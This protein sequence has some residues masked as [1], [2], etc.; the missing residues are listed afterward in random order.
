MKLFDESGSSL[1]SGKVV[2]G[3]CLADFQLG[4]A[5]QAMPSGDRYPMVS[6]RIEE[7][8]LEDHSTEDKPELDII[9]DELFD[10]QDLGNVWNIVF[11]FNRYHSCE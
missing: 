10:P 5:I 7:E 11:G 8:G 6:D 4:Q 1:S 9:D 3:V 2:E